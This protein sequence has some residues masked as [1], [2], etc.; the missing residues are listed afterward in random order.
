MYV[1]DRYHNIPHNDLLLYFVIY[2][3]HVEC[4]IPRYY[5]LELGRYHAS[6]LHSAR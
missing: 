6:H 5:E 2:Y 1:S 4:I 3:N